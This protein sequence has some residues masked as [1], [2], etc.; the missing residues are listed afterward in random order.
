MM[1]FELYTVAESTKPVEATGGL[2][3]V[4]DYSFDQSPRPDVIVVPAVKKSQA[5]LDWLRGASPG[6]DITMSVCTGALL[7]A[8]AAQ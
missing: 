1:P 7:V 4:P 8:E 2:M 6:A 5:M 3:I